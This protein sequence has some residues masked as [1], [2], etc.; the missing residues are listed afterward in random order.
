[1][2]F[3]SSPT[4]DWIILETLVYVIAPSLEGWNKREKEINEKWKWQTD[5]VHHP[6]EI[7]IHC[8]G[9]PSLYSTLS[10]QRE[11]EKKTLHLVQSHGRLV[12][13]W[14]CERVCIC[15]HVCTSYLWVHLRHW[16]AGYAALKGCVSAAI[17]LSPSLCV[18]HSHPDYSV[19]LCFVCASVSFTISALSICSPLS[20]L[21][22]NCFQRTRQ[23]VG[24]VSHSQPFTSRTGNDL[25]LFEREAG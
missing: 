22:H 23:N 11:G 19:Y 9:W 12:C 13:L 6:C 25:M 4:Q 8:Q 10:H 14:M 7:L 16:A 2:P 1:M 15:L 3:D 17:S 18:S 20:M 21:Y 5:N 24:G